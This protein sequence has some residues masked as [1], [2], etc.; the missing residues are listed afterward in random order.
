MNYKV[1]KEFDSSNGIERFYIKKKYF[2][3]FWLYIAEKYCFIGNNRKN[4]IA[5]NIVYVFIMALLGVVSLLVSMIPFVIL[6]YKN[7]D[8]DILNYC[9]SAVTFAIYFYLI[10]FLY[11][12]NRDDYRSKEDAIK[13]LKEI[14]KRQES[15][16]VSEDVFEINIK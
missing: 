13:E 4:D 2:N 14:I 6:G 7:I 9:Y 3:I 8:S 5:D 16:S 1:V 12:L 10:K 15:K 11:Y